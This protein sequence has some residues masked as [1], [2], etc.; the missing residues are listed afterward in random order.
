MH[1][2]IGGLDKKDDLREGVEYGQIWFM[3]NQWA[4]HFSSGSQ[5]KMGAA[6]GLRVNGRLDMAF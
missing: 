5:R 2:G 3:L 1:D 4:F 6:S